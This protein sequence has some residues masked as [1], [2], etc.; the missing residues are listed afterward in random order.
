MVAWKDGTETWFLLKDLKAS[1]PVEVTKFTRAKGIDDE[2]AF[3]WWVP[4]TLRKRDIAISK[5]KART[6]KT[7]HKCGF[8]IPTSV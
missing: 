6:R 7:S 2:P 5:L 1:N 3:A 8:E 4:C